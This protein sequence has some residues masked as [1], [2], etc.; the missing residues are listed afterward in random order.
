[1]G[2]SVDYPGS[3]KGRWVTHNNSKGFSRLNIIKGG[4]ARLPED[5]GQCPLEN[6]L[7]KHVRIITD[8]PLTVRYLFQ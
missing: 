4:N 5:A 1:M 2:Q 3:F 7:N 6:R 8:K